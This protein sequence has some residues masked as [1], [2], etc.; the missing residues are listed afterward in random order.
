ME[1]GISID[2]NNKSRDSSYIRHVGYSENNKGIKQYFSKN[3]VC[4]ISR[5]VTE[6]LQ[7]VNPDN[8]PIV[9]PDHIITNVMDS[10]YSTFRPETG[11]I[12]AR[13]NIPNSAQAS[14]E[15]YVQQMIDQTIEIIV[16]DVRNNLETESNNSKLSIWTTVLGD[17]NSHGLQSHP[18]IKLR[19]K[20]PNPMQFNMNY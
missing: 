7:G 8:R 10:V 19:N 17:F 11:G 3:T 13:Y 9:V 12:Y 18:Q 16:T 5:K 20:R 6:L 15:S 1:Y 14:S 2:D 4:T